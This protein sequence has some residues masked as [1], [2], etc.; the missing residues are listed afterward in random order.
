MSI[1]KTFKIERF[2]SYSGDQEK[3]TSSGD[4]SK[5]ALITVIIFNSFDLMCIRCFSEPN[6][7][8]INSNVS[9]ILDY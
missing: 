4:L 6:S 3:I 1:V 8:K 2:K 5:S 9:C 7:L